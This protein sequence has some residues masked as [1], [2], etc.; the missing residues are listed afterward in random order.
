MAPVGL[1][2]AIALVAFVTAHLALVVGLARRGR[3]GAVGTVG[4]VRRWL[5]PAV[6]LVVVPLAPWWGY[7]AG[8][9]TWTYAWGTALLLYALGTIV[10]AAR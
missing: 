1:A 10:A 9:R 6:A 2:L 5:R 7:R 3:T 4:T 8:M